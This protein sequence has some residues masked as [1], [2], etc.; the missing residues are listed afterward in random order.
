MTGAVATS[1]PRFDVMR[2]GFKGRGAASFGR[3]GRDGR[4]DE[5][6]GGWGRMRQK[7]IDQ[8]SS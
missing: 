8:L 3:D 1:G 2:R 4:T 6:E 7:N 5:G